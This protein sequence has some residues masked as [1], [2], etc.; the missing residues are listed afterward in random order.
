MEKMKWIWSKEAGEDIGW[1]KT[2]IRWAEE[3]YAKIFSD[4]YDEELGVK[5][6]F[7]KVIKAIQIEK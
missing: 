4:I 1:N 7:E 6:N 5:E 2:G 3:K